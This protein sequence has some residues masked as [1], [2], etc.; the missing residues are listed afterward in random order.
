MSNVQLKEQ[1][2]D[3]IGRFERLR[4][5]ALKQIV[6]LLDLHKLSLGVPIESRVKSWMSVEGKLER[7]S[8]TVAHVH[9]LED[10]VGI[11]VILLFRSDLDAAIKAIG[12]TFDVVSSEDAGDRLGDSQFGYQSRHIIVR[13]PQGWLDV[14]VFRDAGDLC[15]ELQVRTLAQH[16]WAAVSH[17]LQY[18]N[19]DSVPPPIRR[20]INRA[21]ALLETVDL[22]FDRVL[23]A[24][25]QYVESSPSQSE[26][27]APLNVDSLALLLEQELPLQ[28]KRS[29]E[30]FADLL[31]ELSEL[32]VSSSERLRDILRRNR[33]EIMDADRSQAALFRD[34]RFHDE[35]QR[36]RMKRGVYY[37]LTGLVRHGL[38]LEFGDEAMND[39]YE[40]LFRREQKS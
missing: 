35:E 20:A 33:D 22:E 37:S 3:G 39:F 32:G 13:I 25:R 6:E 24:R 10:L 21:S 16:I 1:Y 5:S 29:D 17:K 31:D 40:D 15:V 34:A 2:F 36:E 7:K 19:E 9:D 26:P 38:G 28:N 14:P 4:E 30:D 23:E 11:R 8:M 27:A 18:K 12:E